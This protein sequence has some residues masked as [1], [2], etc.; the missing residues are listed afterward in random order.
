MHVRSVHAALPLFRSVFALLGHVSTLVGYMI[1]SSASVYRA[2]LLSY[3]SLNLC[4]NRKKTCIIAPW[5][6]VRFAS[7]LRKPLQSDFALLC[8]VS[9]LEGYMN[10]SSASVYKTCLLSYG[11]LNLCFNRKKPCIIAPL[12]ACSL[13]FCATETTSIGLCT[14]LSC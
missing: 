3:G 1:P 2:S 12:E 7:A 5:R 14:T 8:H 4:F 10:P 6:H 9:T 13:R 11:S